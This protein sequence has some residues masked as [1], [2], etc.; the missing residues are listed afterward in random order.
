M[1]KEEKDLCGVSSRHRKYLRIFD[2]SSTG[3]MSLKLCS[4]WDI[5]SVLLRGFILT[6]TRE[7]R[8]NYLGV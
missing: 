2:A 6:N 8:V 5:C 3:K 1:V 4:L 7:V